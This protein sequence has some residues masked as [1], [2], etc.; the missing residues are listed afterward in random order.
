MR[1]IVLFCRCIRKMWVCSWCYT[2]PGYNNSL[3]KKCKGS[4]LNVDRIEHVY[5]CEICPFKEK[6]SKN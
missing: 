3:F 4:G 1:L 2:I 6:E 5:S